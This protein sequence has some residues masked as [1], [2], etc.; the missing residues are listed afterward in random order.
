MALYSRV[1]TWVSEV[2]TSTDLNAEFN[3]VQSSVNAV[4]TAQISANAV[5]TAKIA[6]L[7]VTTG[8]LAD[9]AVSTA[10]LADNS[11]TSGK[12][13]FYST[14]VLTSQK[15]R[16]V[17]AYTV[18]S[19]S[20]LGNFGI[21]IPRGPS[22]AA[23]TATLVEVC[24]MLTGS[25]ARTFT[26]YRN[27]PTWTSDK[28]QT[29]PFGTGIATTLATMATTSSDYTVRTQSFANSALLSGDILFA[30]INTAS[31]VSVSFTYDI[32]Y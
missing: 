4:D 5:T 30:T 17:E 24:F 7:N 26:V 10:K 25:V 11:V 2:L 3:A 19:S 18:P 20:S 21:V 15:R 16:V 12:V 28:I 1:K 8:K 23:L 13:S 29:D 27:R 9:A 32:D 6:D 22:A 14:I 31:T